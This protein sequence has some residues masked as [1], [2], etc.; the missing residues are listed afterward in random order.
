MPSSRLLG[1]AL[2][3]EFL[4]G[5]FNGRFELPAELVVED[6]LFGYVSEQL[7]LAG[8]EKPEQLLFEIPEVGHLE[9]PRVQIEHVAGIRL[10]ARRTPEKK[11]NFPV[12]RGV[13]RKIVVDAKHVAAGVAIVLADRA[14]RVRSE[15]RDGIVFKSVDDRERQGWCAS[16]EHREIYATLPIPAEVIKPVK[17]WHCDPCSDGKNPKS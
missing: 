8:I 14:S 11:R 2:L 7:G 4:F 16:G 13:L 15:E 17:T 9:E 3:L 1:R 10:A 12:R 6:L 5:L